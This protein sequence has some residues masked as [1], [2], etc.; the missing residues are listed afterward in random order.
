MIKSARNRV[1]VPFDAATQLLPALGS[2]LAYCEV[3]V[4]VGVV[5]TVDLCVG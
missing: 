4:G 3:C 1:F 5:A 2:C